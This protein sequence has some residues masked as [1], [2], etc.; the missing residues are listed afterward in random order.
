MLV[1]TWHTD[2]KDVIFETFSRGGWS[3]VRSDGHGRLI[4]V[5]ITPNAT[6]CP[7]RC[8]LAGRD[9][10]GFTQTP[11]DEFNRSDAI[12]CLCLAPL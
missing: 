3:V 9:G 8:Q 4:R 2:G 10:I 6:D 12:F 1:K 11:Q 7:A 5:I